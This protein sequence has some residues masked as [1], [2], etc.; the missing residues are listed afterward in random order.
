MKK[1]AT[2]A[3]VPRGGCS[4]TRFQRR[5]PPIWKGDRSRYHESDRAW[6]KYDKQAEG[7]SRMY[8]QIWESQAH[9]HGGTHEQG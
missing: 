5:H 2:T 4:L 8:A 6:R 1:R 3:G 9:K 7:E